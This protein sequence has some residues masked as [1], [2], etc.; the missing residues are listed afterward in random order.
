MNNEHWK[1]Q[2][3]KKDK[4]LTQISKKIGNKDLIKAKNKTKT[5]KQSKKTK[6]KKQN[7]SKK[8]EKTKKNP[9]KTT[10]HKNRW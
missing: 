3:E 10:K 8:T 7:K 5:K 2:T 4:Q 9:A 1:Q 6:N